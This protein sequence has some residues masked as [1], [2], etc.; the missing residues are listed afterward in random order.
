[1]T[2]LAPRQISPHWKRRRCLAGAALGQEDPGDG[3]SHWWPGIPR[4]TDRAVS[5][6]TEAGCGRVKEPRYSSYPMA[7]EEMAGLVAELSEFVYQETNDPDEAD[8]QRFYKVERW[9]SAEQYV[10]ELLYASNDLSKAK[11]MFAAWKDGRPRGRYT[12]RQG[13]RVLNRWPPHPK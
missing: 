2:E 1:M 12:L 10:V 11:A 7:V 8:R 13:I 9:D 6:R 3:Q 4:A 5:L